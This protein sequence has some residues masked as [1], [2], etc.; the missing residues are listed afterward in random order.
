MYICNVLL[1]RLLKTPQQPIT[2]RLLFPILPPN[3]TNKY[4][5]DQ[6][7]RKIPLW[8][9]LYLRLIM[10]KSIYKHFTLT[11]VVFGVRLSIPGVHSFGFERI[12]LNLDTRWRPPH[13]IT[14]ILFNT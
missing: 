9:K 2:G 6:T 4:L 8:K 3:E 7:H 10:R 14:F 5:V 12:E 1:I 13:L 11:T